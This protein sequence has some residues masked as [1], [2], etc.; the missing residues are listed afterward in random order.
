[1]LGPMSRF[2]DRL[3]D[4]VLSAAAS[5]PVQRTIVGRAIADTVVVAAAGFHEPVVRSSLLAYGGSATRLWSG[6][7]CESAE[8][9]VML[10][11][12]A[13]HALDYD[14]VYLD[15]ATHPSTVIVP[16]VLDFER[17][18]DAQDIFDA[19][20]AGLVAARAISDRLG[21]SHY[22][23]GWHGTGTVGVFAAT[24]AAAR[25][26]QLDDSQLR[27]AFGLA[28]AMSGGLQINFSTMAKPCQ[29]GFAA[30]AGTRA[31]R[32]AAAGVTAAHDV[33]STSGGYPGLYGEP[34]RDLPASSFSLSPERIAV[35]LYPCCLAA[36]RLVGVALDVRNEVGPA[37][38]S[39]SVTA[40]LLVPRRSIDVLRI[41][42]PRTGLEAKFSAS[43]ATAVALIDGQPTLASFSDTAVTRSDLHAAMERLTIE[44]DP[45]QPGDGDIASGVVRL[46]L[47]DSGRPIAD[48][49]RSAIPGSPED[50]VSAEQFRA[51]A[52][53]CLARYEAST[54]HAF[55]LVAKLRA[56]P[57]AAQ[58]LE[59][60]RPSVLR[61]ISDTLLV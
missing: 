40:R 43:F 36:A 4:S 9:A 14:D 60:P 3:C 16:A 22:A 59:S 8:A 13:A 33:F 50:P 31:A 56:I 46:Q 35:K 48:R 6:E 2:L 1:M 21:P 26:M 45:D 23:R 24:A 57:E 5:T 12:I 28:A 15:S 49:V 61:P 37:F 54:G 47:F 27:A 41:Q 30:A 34:E 44:E 11:A 39:S 52:I 53:A 32:L 38:R 29:A 17:P 18:I 58:W 42:R 25:M 7:T 20:T 19:M 55:P 51:K 10:N